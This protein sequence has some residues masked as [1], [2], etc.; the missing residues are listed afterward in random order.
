LQPNTWFLVG[1]PVGGAAFGVLLTQLVDVWKT[2]R[3]HRHELQQRFFDVKFEAALDLARSLDAVIFAFKARFAEAVEWTRE[4][5]N[6]IWLDLSRDVL[7]LH[8]D[9]LAKNFDRYTAAYAVMDLVFP[10]SLVDSA[11]WRAIGVDLNQ[12]WLAF[13]ERRL[14]LVRQLNA[15]MPESRSE[16][17]R[18]QRARGHFDDGVHQEF[19]R[20]IEAY[21]TGTSDLRSRLPHIA[22]LTESTNQSVRALREELNPYSL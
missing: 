9:A 8:A 13:D 2:S 7:T 4:D 18:A 15:L 11:A 10:S 22:E 12:A 1:L 17:L 16:E 14:M 3:V 19:E 21:K 6:F 20:W 5:E